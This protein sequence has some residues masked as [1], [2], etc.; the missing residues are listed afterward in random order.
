LKTS[1]MKTRG[2]TSL[3]HLNWHADG[4]TGTGCST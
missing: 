1:L 3:N 2:R 4:D